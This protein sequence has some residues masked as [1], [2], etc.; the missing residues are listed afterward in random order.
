MNTFNE[1][2]LHSDEIAKCARKQQHE[3]DG[4]SGWRILVPV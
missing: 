4:T 2:I 3:A 1:D